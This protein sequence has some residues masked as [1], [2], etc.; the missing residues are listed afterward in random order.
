MS[1]ELTKTA[2][3]EITNFIN[4]QQTDDKPI[5]LRVAIKGS[6]CSGFT[7]SLDLTQEKNDHDEIFT[8]HD[9][10]VICDSRSYLYLKGTT[11]DFKDDPIARGFTFD[12][13]NRTTLCPNCPSAQS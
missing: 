4:Q 13:P 7:Y 1:I 11:I 12:N 9:L 8:S 5:F 2:V 3:D 6:G 10:H